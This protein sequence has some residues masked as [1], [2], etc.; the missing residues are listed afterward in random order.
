[1]HH[2]TITMAT[3]AAAT[4][5]WPTQWT[6]EYVNIFEIALVM[7]LE[8]LPNQWEKIAKQVPGKSAA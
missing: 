7:V 3:A 4:M 2:K 8:D 5:Q 6:C 1:M